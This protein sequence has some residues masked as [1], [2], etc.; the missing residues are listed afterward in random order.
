MHLVYFDESGNSGNNLNDPE[1]PIFVLGALIVPETCW[2]AVESDLEA[3]L[4]KHFPEIA[5]AGEEL[6]SGDLRGRP[7]GQPKTAGQGV[8]LQYVRFFLVRHHCFS[9]FVLGKSTV[10]RG[11]HLPPDI[12]SCSVRKFTTKGAFVMAEILCEISP[13]LRATE[14]TVAVKDIYGR[15]QYLRVEE[16]F[17]A[18]VGSQSFLPVGIVGI[19][20]AKAVSLI[21]LP[22]ESDAGVN[23][24]WVRNAELR[25]LREPVA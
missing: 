3:E 2:Q 13:G 17:L 12:R 16:G 7:F 22:H 15:R 21:E 25:G 5:A 20:D 8:A 24:L 1:Q 11:W 23:R 14:K 6:H 9:F 19:D 10:L 18:Q 4:A